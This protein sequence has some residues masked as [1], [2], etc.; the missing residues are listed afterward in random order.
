MRHAP[1][2]KEF[3]DHPRDTSNSDYNRDLAVKDLLSRLCEVD[4]LSSCQ[5]KVLKRTEE[6]GVIHLVVDIT[7]GY[8]G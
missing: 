4:G 1:C 3:V 2:A 8:F 6:D 7:D 5:Y